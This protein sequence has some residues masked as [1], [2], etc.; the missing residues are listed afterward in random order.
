MPAS[1]GQTGPRTE[2]YVV[3]YIAPAMHTRTFWT[4]AEAVE[5]VAELDRN[6]F[7]GLSHVVEQEMDTPKVIKR[8]KATTPQPRL[9]GKER[10]R[11][12]RA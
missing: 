9:P 4:T 3:R 10:N 6:D 12:T 1:D 11:R 2:K 7:M 8:I 5:F